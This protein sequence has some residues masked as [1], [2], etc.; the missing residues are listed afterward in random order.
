M[1]VGLD[2]DA[3]LM[4]GGVSL[5]HHNKVMNIIAY[6]CVRVCVYVRVWGIGVMAYTSQFSPALRFIVWQT[7][8]FQK[9]K[10]EKIQLCKSTKLEKN[11]I[12]QNTSLKNY[13][14]DGSSGFWVTVLGC[15]K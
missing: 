9:C 8:C 11:P 2:V 13:K 12:L 1:Q 7:A 4:T 15:Q 3:A 14:M 10:I 6:L 5:C